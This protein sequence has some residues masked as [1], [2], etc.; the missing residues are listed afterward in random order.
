VRD[1]LSRRLSVGADGHAT[2]HG[3]SDATKPTALVTNLGAGVQAELLR[4]EHPNGI[5]IYIYI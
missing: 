4:V 5:A 3:A 2:K 1:R